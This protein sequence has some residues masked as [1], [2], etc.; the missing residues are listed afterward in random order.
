V[1]PA[2][3]DIE[4]SS[5]RREE[6]EGLNKDI[7]SNNDVIPEKKNRRDE[8]NEIAK[9]FYEKKRMKNRV[10]PTVMDFFCM[11]CCFSYCKKF[12]QQRYDIL[13]RCVEITDKYLQI[14]FIMDKFFE[15][16]Y[17]KKI[18]LSKN[19]RNLLKYQFKYINF[20]NIEASNRFLDSIQS[21]KAEV[22]YK[23]LEKDETDTNANQ[24][25]IEGVR[26]YFNF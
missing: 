22:D 15:I 14:N 10:H 4:L 1:K 8:L 25:L 19:E 16:E 24:K 6:E 26:D 20:N 18:L 23:L 13:Q 17:M 3:A 12:K 5:H 7:L 9:I 2:N 11:N 21:E